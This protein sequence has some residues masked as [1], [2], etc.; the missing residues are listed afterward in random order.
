M[1]L[2]SGKLPGII[3]EYDADARMCR[4]EIP[5][6]TDGASVMPQAVFCTPIGDRSEGDTPTEI[7]VQVGDPVW[8]EF[9]AGDPRFPIV[10]GYRTPRAGN[11]SG[12]RRWRH[13]NIQ[14]VAENVYQVLVGGTTITVTDGLMKVEGADLDVSGNI[15]SGKSITAAQ[16]VTAGLNVADQGGAKTMAGMRQEFNSHA[17]HFDTQNTTPTNQM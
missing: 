15:L 11:S 12:W 7:R 16:N 8:I 10:V 3:R 6:I 13:A 5:G 2:L 4:V 17:G 1:T 9:E 14:L